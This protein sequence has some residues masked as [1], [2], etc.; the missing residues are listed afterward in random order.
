MM[1][2]HE[3]RVAEVAKAFR[4]KMEGKNHEKA[5]RAIE[6]TIFLCLSCRTFLASKDTYLSLYNSENVAACRASQQISPAFKVSSIRI[7]SGLCMETCKLF[8]CYTCLVG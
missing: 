2:V 7:C 1:D 5:G 8:H 6:V 4:G 3:A